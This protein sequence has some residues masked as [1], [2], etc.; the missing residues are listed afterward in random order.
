GGACMKISRGGRNKTPDRVPAP[1][2]TM[3]EDGPRAP[4][5]EPA[6]HAA[7][8]RREVPNIGLGQLLREAD[9]VFNRA[10]RDELAKHNVTFSQYQHL[11][12]LWQ[13][14]GLAQNEL[15]RR[16]GIETASSTTV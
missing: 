11:R 6:R 8:A 2:R 13:D 15:S 1:P 14:D 5:K 12:Q 9:M 4:S 3:P 10:L 16:I 7:R